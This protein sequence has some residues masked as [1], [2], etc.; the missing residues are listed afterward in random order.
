MLEQSIE[1]GLD[2]DDEL[3]NLLVPEANYHVVE[4]QTIEKTLEEGTIKAEK[5]VKGQNNQKM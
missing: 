1:N 4:K 5:N 3:L 2:F